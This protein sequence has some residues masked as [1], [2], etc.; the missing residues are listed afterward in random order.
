MIAPNL[1]LA[2]MLVFVT[3]D[4]PVPSSEHLRG[5]RRRAAR[6]ARSNRSPSTGARA[7]TT[8]CC[9][10]RAAPPVASPSC[11]ARRVGAG[12]RTRSTRWPTSLLLQLAADAEG[13]TPR[14]ARRGGRRRDREHDARVVAKAVADSL[15]VK[16]AAFGGDP[17]PGRILQAVGLL[18]RAVPAASASTS[19]LGGVRRHRRG[20]DPGRVLRR[21]RGRARARR[22]RR[23]RDVVHR[24][25]DRRR[26]R[27][28]AERWVWTCPTST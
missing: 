22:G 23:E 6:A 4:A 25:L 9:C 28:R 11:P 26:P 10:S 1:Q 24:D 5:S 17:N 18:G 12:G 16:T 27:A 14:D 7:P 13:A 15:L 2:T 20:R 21:R 8:P 3:T 19:A